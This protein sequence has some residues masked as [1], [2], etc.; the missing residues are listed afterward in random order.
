MDVFKSGDNSD[1]AFMNSVDGIGQ[2]TDTGVAPDN[3]WAPA[4]F[5]TAHELGHGGSLPDE[6]FERLMYCSAQA[7]GITCNTPGDPF[8]DEGGRP[9]LAASLAAAIPNTPYPMMTH[10]VELRNRYFWH[11][12][13]FARK[14]TGIAFY[15]KHGA[16]AEY[17]VPGHPKFPYR[18]YVYW[19]VRKKMN[20]K[21]GKHG[22]VDI[23]LHTL[24]KEAYSINRIP[25]G[26][27]DGIV[28]ILI[29]IDLSWPAAVA[30]T[31]IR[32]TIRNVFLGFNQQYSATGTTGV[33]T[34]TSKAIRDDVTFTKAEVRFSPRFLVAD[35]AQGAQYVNTYTWL[36]N[37]IGTHF[38][39]NVVDNAGKKMA[40]KV[41]TGFTGRRGGALRLAIDSTGP[42]MAFMGNEV[43]ALLP[44]ILGVKLAG[45]ALAAADLKPLVGSVI[46]TNATVS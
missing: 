39:V 10:M 30:V 13:E 4:C 18:S 28:S 11:N 27:W 38:Q 32:D 3:S 42:W 7:P 24:G 5:T 6:Y 23:Y 40:D 19:P 34:D 22:A 1:R 36:R 14:H 35:P 45:A 41:A 16:Y 43:R 31:D 12:A 44:E 29:K 26:P 21:G 8:V 20:R 15:S 25:N 33:N 17:K 9:D 2:V 46:H 37:S